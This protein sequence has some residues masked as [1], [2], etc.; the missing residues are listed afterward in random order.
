MEG[1]RTEGRPGSCP[2]LAPPAGGSASSAGSPRPE[3]GADP[4]P[5]GLTGRR[6]RPT[7]TSTKLYSQI[8]EFELY[9]SLLLVQTLKQP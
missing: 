2:S 3:P 6:Q 8:R 1:G 9:P 7:V 5:P 4:L